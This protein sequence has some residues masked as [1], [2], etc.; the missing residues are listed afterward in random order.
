MSSPTCVP[1][2]HRAV[3]RAA[4]G[5]RVLHDHVVGLAERGREHR[6][7]LLVFLHQP[8]ELLRRV[9]DLLGRRAEVQQP[10]QPRG[11]TV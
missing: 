3:E 10:A 11:S 8:H 7:H 4:R 5:D 6:V 1:P 2:D 9:A